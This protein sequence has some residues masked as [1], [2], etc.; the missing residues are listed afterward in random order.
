MTVR[1]WYAFMYMFVCV[2]LLQ[3]SVFINAWC[4]MSR[5]TY[6]MQAVKVK[7]PE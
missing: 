4:D 3:Q 5:C 7:L 2:L 6:D 1:S